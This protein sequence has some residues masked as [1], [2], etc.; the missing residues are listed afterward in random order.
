MAKLK[1]N[2]VTLLHLA[3]D[4]VPEAFG[5]ESATAASTPRA[6]QHVYFCSIK[7]SDERITPPETAVG[8]VVCG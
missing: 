2:K 3:Q 6:I 7:V 4:F 5:D 1:Q 8:M